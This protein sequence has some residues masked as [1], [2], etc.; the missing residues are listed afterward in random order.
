M[1]ALA[2]I[3]D[4][5]PST[6][7]LIAGVLQTGLTPESVSVVERLVALREREQEA[8][9]KRAFASAFVKLQAELPRI[10]A[11]KIVPNRDGTP[12][13]TYAPYEEIMQ[14]AQPVLTANGFAV[15]LDSE[16]AD[17]KVTA[18]CTLLHAGGFSKVNKFTCAI[19]SGPPQASESQKDGAGMTYAKRFALCNALN[20]VIEQ[21]TDGVDPNET[22]TA[23]QAEEL[24]QRALACKA[25]LAKFV[26]FLGVSGFDEIRA[27]DY[28]KADKALRMKE[29]VK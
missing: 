5:Q 4:A 8:E 24:R 14:K 27:K 21:D 29:A 9:A 19:G 3:P 20:I 13:Y 28:G 25:D 16:Q 15:S 12:R 26:K 6:L 11:C 23:E 22:I 17:G 7:S 1:N 10:E 2:T 18:F